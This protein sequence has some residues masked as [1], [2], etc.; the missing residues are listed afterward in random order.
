MRLEEFLICFS[1]SIYFHLTVA[2]TPSLEFSI[3]R[4]VLLSLGHCLR[5]GLGLT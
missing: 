4:I 2:A 5:L 1:Y 3:S